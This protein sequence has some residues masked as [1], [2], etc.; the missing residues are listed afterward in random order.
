MK[1]QLTLTSIVYLPNSAIG[2]AIG[3]ARED[4]VC[5]NKQGLLNQRQLAIATTH[6]QRKPLSSSR[7]QRFTRAPSSIPPEFYYRPDD[8]RAAHPPDGR[9]Q[10]LHSRRF[11]R[12][13]AIG[14]IFVPDA[15]RDYPRSVPRL[16]GMVPRLSEAHGMGGQ[17]SLHERHCDSALPSQRENASYLLPLG[18]QTSSS[19]IIGMHATQNSRT[20]LVCST[21]YP[22]GSQTPVAAHSRNRRARNE[23]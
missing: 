8:V 23:Q 9:R 14:G 22:L 3:F 13:R 6:C 5:R 16:P 1:S 7:K 17:A 10:A 4:R 18:T 20:G 11:A 19:C 15:R 12:R 21:Q 2:K